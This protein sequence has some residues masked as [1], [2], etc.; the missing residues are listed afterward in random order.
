MQQTVDGA[1][2]QRRGGGAGVSA[3]VSSPSSVAV[4]NPSTHHDPSH[5]SVAGDGIASTD[6]ADLML[7]PTGGAGASGAAASACE[8]GSCGDVAGCGSSV[9]VEDAARVAR[10]DRRA[11]ETAELRDLLAAHAGPD[12]DISMYRVDNSE[13]VVCVACEYAYQRQLKSQEFH[14]FRRNGR[15]LPQF[16]K[17]LRDHV[18]SNLRHQEF[19]RDYVTRVAD[20]LHKPGGGASVAQQ[21]VLRF[22]G[23]SSSDPSA[24]FHKMVPCTGYRADSLVLRTRDA[25]EDNFVVDPMMLLHDDKPGVSR[26]ADDSGKP[27]K[28]WFPDKHRGAY[29]SP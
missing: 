17:G 7:E 16:A 1:S 18:V 23:K 25:A 8:G 22:F 15:S 13:A 24:C 28:K 19:V 21:T 27:V 9:D 4:T 6:E 14:I 2:G 12:V 5:A 20:K 26:R 10:V 3:L 29:F 11:A